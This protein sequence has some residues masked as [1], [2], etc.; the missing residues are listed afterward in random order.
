MKEMS[1]PKAS[2]NEARIYKMRD[3]TEWIDYGPY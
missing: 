3:T 2:V 1:R